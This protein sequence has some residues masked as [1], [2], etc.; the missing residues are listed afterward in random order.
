MT[1]KLTGHLSVKEE[2]DTT[3]LDRF[4]W[5][6]ELTGS[7]SL[8]FLS[9]LTCQEFLHVVLTSKS[10]DVFCRE[11]EVSWRKQRANIGSAFWRSKDNITHPM[12]RSLYDAV[13]WQERFSTASE[14]INPQWTT[15]FSLRDANFTLPLSK[16]WLLAITCLN[17]FHELQK[18]IF[19][20]VR[21]VEMQIRSRS[22]SCYN[23]RKGERHNLQPNLEHHPQIHV[24]SC[25]CRFALIKITIIIISITYH[26]S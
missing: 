3:V 22:E 23:W 25:S 9:S 15:I 19:H 21:N 1:M 16:K 11:R 12:M 18:K 5:I 7:L 8:V 6:S 24:F 26:V 17:H 4:R 13:R 20:W 10:V 14:A 2:E